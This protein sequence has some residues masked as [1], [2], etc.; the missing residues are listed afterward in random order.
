MSG[1]KERLTMNEG[2]AEFGEVEELTDEDKEILATMTG[3]QTPDETATQD[4]GTTTRKQ[5]LLAAMDKVRN[6]K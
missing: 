5:R 6:K 3:T 1:L 4:S 2:D